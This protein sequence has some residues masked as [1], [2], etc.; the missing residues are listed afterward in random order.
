M[1]AM[2]NVSLLSLPVTMGANTLSQKFVFIET[3]GKAYVAN[4]QTVAHAFRVVG[5]TETSVTSC[6]KTRIVNQGLSI[7]WTGLTPGQPYWLGTAGGITLT[8]PTTGFAQLVGIAAP[9]G[10]ELIVQLLPPEIL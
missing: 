1:S 2:A 7:G 3:D 5:V 9:N 10:T 4:N 6:T 8:K